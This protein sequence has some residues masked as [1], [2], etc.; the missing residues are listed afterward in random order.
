MLSYRNIKS[1]K[2]Q[3]VRDWL[4]LTVFICI[5]HSTESMRIPHIMHAS[6]RAD[7][8]RHAAGIT[9]VVFFFMKPKLFGMSLFATMQEVEDQ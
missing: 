9:I 2:H 4:C 6:A 3:V 7:S 5:F 1:Q 8:P